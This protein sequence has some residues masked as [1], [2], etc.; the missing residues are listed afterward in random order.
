MLIIRGIEVTQAI[1]YYRADQHLTDVNDRGSDNTLRLIA[2]K[3]AW[4]RVY[5]EEDTSGSI[6]N[7][8][9]TLDVG[10]GFMNSRAGSP[11]QVFAPQGPGNVTASFDPYYAT[12]RST[13]ALTLN[14]VVPADTMWGPMSFKVSVTGGG[15]TASKNLSI[16]ASLR[17]TLRLRG[18]MIGYNGPNP[19]NPS[20]TLTVAAP[21]VADLQTTAGFAMRI[22]PVQ[23]AGVF[24][25][26]ATITRN[27][28]LT[29]TATNG[30]CTQAWINL[31]AAIA[32]A[33]TADGNQPDFLYYGLLAAG[34]PNSSN[35]GGCASSGVSSGFS[36]GQGALAHEIGHMCG[37]GHGPCGGVGTSADA[38]YPSYE[39]YDTP[40]NRIATIGEYGLDITTGT[41]LT[42]Q[43]A[44]D[45]MSYCGP[46]W[47]SIYGHQALIENQALD[48]GT[49]GFAKRWWKDYYAYDPWWWLKH[50]W[51]RPWWIEDVV[52][53]EDF[54][55]MLKV[56]S[57]I[58]IRHPDG[59]VEVLHV[60]R[61]EVKSA[62]LIGRAGEL[63]VVLL[64]KGG[65]L[66]SAAAIESAAHGSCGCHD[67]GGDAN[68]P[69][70]FQAY[71]EDVA[72]GSAILIRNGKETLWRRNAPKGKPG[73]ST[74][75]VKPDAEKRKLQVKWK[76]K[77]RGPFE[78]WVRVSA[79]D[80]KT[81]Q[82]AATGIQ[83][84]DALVDT[85]QMPS[86]RLLVQVVVHDGFH[87]IASKPVP[88][89]NATQPPVPALLSPMEG[90]ELEAGGT[91]MLWGSIAVQPGA[92]TEGYRYT[93]LLDGKQAG[94]GVQ[95]V[96]V[97]PP[98][99]KHRAELVVRDAKGKSVASTGV[100][101]TSIRAEDKRPG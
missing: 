46:G 30:G 50:P 88:F 71:L 10:Y 43:V 39:P 84:D 93:W 7:V 35:N 87:S 72:P 24:Q 56:I 100:S 34:F 58:G 5:V 6:A 54:Y 23:A 80:G 74:P 38:N 11:N 55:R 96:T 65:E 31:N 4:V 48:P 36:G 78:A 70:M 92:E 86:G 16:T 8:T 57:L 62:E 1:Q 91:L 98:P 25:A 59:R 27:V 26:A 69:V 15:Q 75:T 28:A 61:T 17:Q 60:V 68:Q 40:A 47:I 18:I 83:V 64:G 66:A 76:R 67:G 79:D 19:S 73:V 94:E 29:G 42:P 22:M 99:G 51:R 41:V 77:T 95:W 81:W 90:Q 32:A 89:D 44:R 37:R 12:I 52:I 45:Y 2:G 53:P 49:V 14:F 21:T 13:P 85:T 97:V 20:A 101:F 82:A 63:R 3:S 9:G 33:K